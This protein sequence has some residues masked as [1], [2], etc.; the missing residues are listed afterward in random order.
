[1]N[2]FN[3]LVNFFNKINIKNNFMLIFKTLLHFLFLLIIFLNINELYSDDV[4]QFSKVY[5]PADVEFEKTRTICLFPFRNVENNSQTEY[6]SKG[7]PA[8]LASTFKTI[9]YAF[10]EKPLPMKIQYEYGINDKK[11]SNTNLDKSIEN[12]PRYIKIEIKVLNESKPILRED[13]LQQGKS[14]SCFYIISGEYKLISTDK[15]S[16]KIEITESKL[17][18]FEEFN[19]S[20]TL[21]RAFQELRDL[22]PEL[23]NKYFI[24]GASTL[25]INTLPENEMFI[26]IDGE[27]IGKSPL[28]KAPI[29]PGKHKILIIKEGF[30]RLEQTI[31]VN[32]SGDSSFTFLLKKILSIGK[33]SIKTIPEGAD[34]YYGNKYLGTS[35]IDSV[36]VPYG[37]NRLKISK[38]GYIDKYQG[39]EI[40]NDKIQNFSFTLKEGETDLYYKYNNNIFLDYSNF[41]LGNYSLYSTIVFY[42]L[43][44]YSGYRESNEKDRLYGKAIFNSL[45]FYQG[46]ALA[47]NNSTTYGDVFLQSLA[48]QQYLVD[49]VEEETYKYRMGQNIGIGGVFSMLMLSGY[50]YYKGFNSDSFEIGLKPASGVNQSSE[51]SIK[52]NF[53]F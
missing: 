1:M 35:P 18:K 44:M 46:L 41:D 23:K 32:S 50:F 45:T 39:I 12:D 29:L 47:A 27:L 6:L 20:T 52:Y 24:S 15:L 48:Y 9:K 30:S 2:L 22:I 49:Q 28:V 36:D 25:T 11:V 8:I 37:Q 38:L 3:L 34:V 43:Y 26:Y 53:K 10:D 31:S 16:I 4:F 13:S 19:Y 14:N 21:K 40:S 33:I 5:L 7:L 51:A 42:G 17:G